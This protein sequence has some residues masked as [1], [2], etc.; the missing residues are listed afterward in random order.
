MYQFLPYKSRERHKK[1]TAILSLMNF[2]VHKATSRPGKSPLLIR[3]LRKNSVFLNELN[4]SGVSSP[5]FVLYIY[6]IAEKFIQYNLILQE[7]GDN[8]AGTKDRTNIYY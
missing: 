5:K 3:I 2:C 8:L 1:Q 6:L 4:I 7:I